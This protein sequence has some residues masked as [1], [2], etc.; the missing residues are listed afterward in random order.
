[1]LVYFQGKTLGEYAQA[2]FSIHLARVYMLCRDEGKDFYCPGHVLWVF[3]SNLLFRGKVKQ[4]LTWKKIQ[5]MLLGQI[6]AS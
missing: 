4:L 5:K 2:V 1:M 6:L 3:E